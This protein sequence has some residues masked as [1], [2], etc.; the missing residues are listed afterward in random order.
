MS[1]FNYRPAIHHPVY[2]GG[3]YFAL[4]WAVIDISMTLRH[5]FLYGGVTPAFFHVFVVL[6]LVLPLFKRSIRVDT[7][8]KKLMYHSNIPGEPWCL[9]FDKPMFDI[10]RDRRIGTLIIKT[11]K[12]EFNTQITESYEKV[13]DMEVAL[14]KEVLL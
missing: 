11:S 7:V 12:E 9:V 6:A 2:K 8:T 14:I 10:E 1:I 13:K 3:Y 5:F 4:F